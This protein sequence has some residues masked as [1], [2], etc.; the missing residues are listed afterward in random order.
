MLALPNQING[1][2]DLTVGFTLV[3]SVVWCVQAKRS[4]IVLMRERG[5]DPAL[6]T[7][8]CAAASIG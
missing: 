6:I 8:P 7:N 2:L 3:N 1:I 5:S 4:G